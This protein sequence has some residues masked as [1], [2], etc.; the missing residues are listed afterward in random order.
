MTLNINNY[1]Y[2]TLLGI[3]EILKSIFKNLNLMAEI[4]NNTNINHNK[5]YLIYT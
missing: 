4:F 5:S 3:H 2:V 1:H